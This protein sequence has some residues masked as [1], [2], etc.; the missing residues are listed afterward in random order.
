MQTATIRAYEAG[1]LKSAGA[2][3]LARAFA[4]ARVAGQVPGLAELV[5]RTTVLAAGST[6]L[7]WSLRAV[8][9]RLFHPADAVGAGIGAEDERARRPGAVLQQRGVVLGR[10]VVLVDGGGRRLDR[11]EAVPIVE[12]VEVA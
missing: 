3:L 4:E 9:Q 11:R 2:L 1:T 12:R 8:E 5:A 7:P 6:G 10:G